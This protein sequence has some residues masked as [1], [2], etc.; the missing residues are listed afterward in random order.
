MKNRIAL[1]ALIL[2]PA[3]LAAQKPGKM[4][5][6]EMHRLHQGEDLAWFACAP[7]NGF[8]ECRICVLWENENVK[9][10]R[11]ARIIIVGDQKLA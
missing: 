1:A 10:A 11:D 6:E 3:Y 4:S 5:T 9:T 7:A 8:F 2:L